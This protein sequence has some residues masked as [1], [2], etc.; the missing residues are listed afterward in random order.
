VVG[1]ARKILP[2]SAGHPNYATV[3]VLEGEKYKIHVSFD[4]KLPSF[5]INQKCSM[6]VGS[7]MLFEIFRAELCF[8]C[9]DSVLNLIGL[10]AVFPHTS[11]WDKFTF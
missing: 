4:Q 10:I 3:C 11:C 7:Y 2:W 5:C 6:G 9:R 8:N 1:D